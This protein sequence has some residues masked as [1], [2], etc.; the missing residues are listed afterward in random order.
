MGKCPYSTH[1]Q[2]R[3]DSLQGDYKPTEHGGLTKDGS[4]DGRVKQSSSGVS[5]GGSSYETTS[6]GIESSSS[7][8]YYK[9]SEHGGLTKDGQPD[10]RVGQRTEDQIPYTTGDGTSAGAGG[11]TGDTYKPTEHGGLTKDGNVDGR[12]KAFQT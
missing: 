6:S 12:T 10:S 8:E 5:T 3:T 9:P 2:H 7:G 11:A 4:I 1:V